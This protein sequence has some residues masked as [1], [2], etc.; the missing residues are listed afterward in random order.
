MKVCAHFNI[1]PFQRGHD[2]FDTIDKAV[3]SFAEALKEIDPQPNVY[4]QLPTMN[5]SAQCADC[6][7]VSNFHEFPMWIFSTGPRGGITKARG[8]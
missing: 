2:R 4:D 5:V 8:Y 6:D 7:S 1:T 3:E